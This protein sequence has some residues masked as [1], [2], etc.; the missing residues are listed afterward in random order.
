MYSCPVLYL[1][2]TPL[3]ILNLRQDHKIPVAGVLA[4]NHYE[5]QVLK[6]RVY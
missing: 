5:E 3:P 6:Q 4:L 1:P 2:V